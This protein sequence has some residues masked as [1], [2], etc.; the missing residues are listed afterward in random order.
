MDK[1]KTLADLRARKNKSQAEISKYLGITPQGYGYIER[2]ERSL[3]IEAA[4]KL[5][6]V[7]NVSIEEVI[8]LALKKQ[9]EVV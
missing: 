6:D 7:F 4:V 5:A 3:R 9:Q 1:A 8:C 2:G